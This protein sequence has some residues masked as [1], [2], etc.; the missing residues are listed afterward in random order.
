MAS[1]F[2]EQRHCCF[3]Y[4]LIVSLPERY[5]NVSR[6]MTAVDPIRSLGLGLELGRPQASK[7]SRIAELSFGAKTGTV[8]GT[9]SSNCL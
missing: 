3:A 4:L 9:A 5:P 7:N 8:F 1:G 2:R 6:Y